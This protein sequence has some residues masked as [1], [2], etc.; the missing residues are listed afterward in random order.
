LKIQRLVVDRHRV[1][2]KLQKL[3]DTGKIAAMCLVVV[4]VFVVVGVIIML[5]K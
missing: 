2:E 4:A 1:D 3:I 5:V